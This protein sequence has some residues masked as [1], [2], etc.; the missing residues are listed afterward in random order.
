MGKGTVE[1][2]SMGADP[3]HLVTEVQS[4]ASGGCGCGMQ[5]RVDIRMDK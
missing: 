2:T 3:P 1:G 4:E 5:G